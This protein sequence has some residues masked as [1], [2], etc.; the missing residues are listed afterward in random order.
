MQKNYVHPINNAQVLIDDK[1][2]GYISLLHPLT[3]NAINKKSAIAVLEIDFTDFAKLIPLKL[4]VKMPSKYQFTVLDFN[5]VMDK[6]VV[7]A[8][9]VENLQNIVTNLNYEI[10]LKDIYE[11]AEMLGKKSMTYAVKLWSDD[12][13]LSG[14]EIENFHSSFIQNAKNFGYE[15]KM[16]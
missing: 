13:T 12:H 3:K 5:F 14:E 2:I 8:D 11:S 1:V 16:M 10:S 9:S 4:Q 15:L 7:Y 6:G